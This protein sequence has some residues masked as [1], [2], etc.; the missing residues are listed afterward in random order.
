MTRDSRSPC[1]S[2][3]GARRRPPRQQAPAAARRRRAAAGHV[4]RRGELRRGGRVVTDAQGNVVTDLTADDFEVL[5]DGRPQKVAAFSLVNIPIERAERPLFAPAPIEPDVQTNAGRRR[6]HL[7]DRARRP[8][9]RLHQHA[10]RQ[11]GARQFI[12][13]NFGA[14]DLAAVVYTS[15]RA[16]DAQDFTN[17]PRLLLAADR[18]VHRPQARARRR[19]SGSTSMRASIPAR[20]H[21]RAGS[22]TR[23][24][25]SARFR[26]RSAMASVRKLAEFMAGVR[27]RRKAMLLISEGIDYDIYER[28][29][30]TRSASAVIAA[31]RTTRSP[32]RRAATSA[33]TRSTR[34]GSPARRPRI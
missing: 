29:S 14:N 31:T 13:Q 9:H 34:A 30:T 1:S 33:S 26:A 20:A 5:E 3:P 23:A 12:E 11:G 19:S 16:S 21:G 24:R 15:G 25:W 7:P 22:T 8:A 2:P 27:G 18:Q 17:N 10:A 32:R 28:S 4:P 6:P